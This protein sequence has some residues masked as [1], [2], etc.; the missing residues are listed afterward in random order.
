MIISDVVAVLIALGVMNQGL[1]VE[2]WQLKHY[3]L[4]D[5][6]KELVVEDRYPCEHLQ[7]GTMLRQASI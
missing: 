5:V 1:E 7:I 6:F 4:H 3:L 2:I